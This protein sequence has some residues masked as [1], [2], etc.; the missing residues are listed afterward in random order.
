M[1]GEIELDGIPSFDV[2]VKAES[3]QD[4]LF[5]VYKKLFKNTAREEVEFEELQVAVVLKPVGQ[6]KPSTSNLLSCFAAKGWL[7]KLNLQTFAEE[8]Q[9][10]V[11]SFSNF[12]HE[13]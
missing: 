3:L 10:Q 9:K 6:R 8:G 1:S 5:E 2:T 4:D 7:Y 13:I 12:R 11:A